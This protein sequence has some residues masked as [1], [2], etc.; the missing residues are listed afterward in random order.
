MLNYKERYFDIKNKGKYALSEPMRL[1]KS[2]AGVLSLF[3]SAVI[4]LLLL[5]GA[6]LIFR[7]KPERLRQRQ[8]EGVCIRRFV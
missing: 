6:N 5:S 1:I 3:S 4:A 7:L 2:A 8:T